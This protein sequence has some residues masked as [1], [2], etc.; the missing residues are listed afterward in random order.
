MRLKALIGFTAIALS[1]LIPPT[2]N[3]DGIVEFTHRGVTI[4]GKPLPA[5][6]NFDISIVGPKEG[7]ETIR[8]ALD[9]L[10]KQSAFNGRAIDKLKSAGNVYI[11]YDPEFPKRELTQVTIAAYIPEYFQREGTAKDFVSVVSRFGAKWEPRE[12]APILAHELTGHGM[13]RYRG[14]IEKVREVD[15]ECEAYLYQEKAYQDLGF[16]KSD[17]EMIN[18]RQVLERHW[19]ADFKI[20]MK[21]NKPDGL[22][23]WD[24]LNPDVPKILKD[25]LVYTEALTRSGVSG[26]A[27]FNATKDQRRAAASEVLQLTK[28]EDPEDHYKLARMYKSG[29]GVSKANP[30]LSLIWTK[31]AARAGHTD[32]LYDLGAAYLEGKVLK[33][34]LKK[35]AKSFEE[36]AEKGNPRAAYTYGVLLLQG[37]GVKRDH[38]AARKWL[39]MALDSGISEAQKALDIIN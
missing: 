34:N 27:V 8:A 9:V 22:K 1:T 23:Y 11:I 12:L 5:G 18:F 15:L 16:D 4:V 21:K 32:A 20:W 24:Q 29:I 30:K 31:K 17:K 7:A 13:Q 2:A 6:V 3:A 37:N 19:C 28:S 35:A 38:I 14:R 10:Y 39:K 26:R 33:K 25:Y 36:A